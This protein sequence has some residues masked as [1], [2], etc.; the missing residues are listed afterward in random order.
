[1]PSMAIVWVTVAGVELG[2]DFVT[3]TCD[4]MSRLEMV[5]FWASVK[6]F[7]KIWMLPNQNL[8]IG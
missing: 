8:G 2:N 3:V 7:I 5:V 4:P 1:M 6:A